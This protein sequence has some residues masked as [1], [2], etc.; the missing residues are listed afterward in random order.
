MIFTSEIYHG[1]VPN[2]NEDIRI[3]MAMD[4]YPG[5]IKEDLNRYY[6]ISLE[7]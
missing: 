1:V 7:P 4:F 3:S 5:V 2:E 6:I